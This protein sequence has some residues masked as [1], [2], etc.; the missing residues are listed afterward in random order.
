MPAPPKPIYHLT[1][2]TGN[3]VMSPR[4]LVEDDVVDAMSGIIE[5]G[6]GQI[7]PDL[8]GYAV[9]ISGSKA[10]QAWMFHIE[11]PDAEV[12]L[13]C[14]LAANYEASEQ[15]WPEISR[16][17]YANLGG[18]TSFEVSKPKHLPWLAVQLIT[19]LAPPHVFKR[20]GDFERCLAWAL[21]E[22]PEIK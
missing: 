16:P 3:G 13:M 2:N 17:V 20:L 21:L 7:F 19:P 8:P 9:K 22:H 14:G 11:N 12:L 1:L 18:P 6:G 10:M 15:L 4:N 5:H